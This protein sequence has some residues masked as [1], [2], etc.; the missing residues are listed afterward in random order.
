MISC[1]IIQ[2]IN[3]LSKIEPYTDFKFLIWFNFWILFEFNFLFL[4]SRVIIWYLSETF[5]DSCRSLN[6]LL[7]KTNNILSIIVLKANRE[8]NN[9]HKKYISICFSV[10]NGP[11]IQ[12]EH[13]LIKNVD[14]SV[15]LYPNRGSHCTV[16][17]LDCK[18]PVL[19][20]Q[21]KIYFTIVT[22]IHFEKLSPLVLT[23][24]VKVLHVLP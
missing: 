6:I 5:Y 15:T 17:G 22:E 11:G 1:Y 13:C 10:L 8:L 7:L 2:L 9:C 18:A 14:G 3:Y 19:L 16:N 21:G 4:L 20:K 24:V 23:Q 12:R